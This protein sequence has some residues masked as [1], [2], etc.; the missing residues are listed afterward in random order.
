MD[1]MR[2]VVL[3]FGKLRVESELRLVTAA[4]LIVVSPPAAAQIGTQRVAAGL[5]A[6]TF[7]AAPPGDTERVFITELA[8]RILILNLLTDTLNATPFL[9]LGGSPDQGLQGL[10]FHPDYA[11]NGHFFVYNQTT[12]ESRVTRYTVST[13]PELADPSSAVTIFERDQP[14]IQHNGGWIGFGPDGYLYIP[15]GDGTGGH[16]PAGN[17]QTTL[18]SL[19]GSILRIDPD[20]DDFPAD[21]AKNYAIPPDNPF[22]GSVGD[23]EIWAFGLRNPFRCSFD[24]L[25]GDFYIADVG[26]ESYEEV[27]FQAAD[28]TGGENYGWRLREGF[29]ATPTGGVG[30]P[31]PGR[32]DPLYAYSHGFGNSEGFSVTGGYVYRGPSPTFYGKYFFGDY[33]SARIWSIEHDGAGGLTEFTDWTDA[34]TPPAGQ[35]TIDEIVGFGEDAVGNLY[36]VD[37]GGEVFRV[38]GDP[39]MAAVP[40]LGGRGGGVLSAG[41]LAIGTF[42]A[43]RRQR[44]PRRR[45]GPA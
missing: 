9:A 4:A 44:G 28:G 20:G 42:T 34:F 31:L 19:S 18:G 41:L 26:Q 29:D 43:R 23:D 2:R 36:I 10:A 35:G 15:L 7:L 16:D 30:G 1:L 6:P 21:P 40:A 33:V 12:T 11:V 14:M 39:P 17:A 38:F 32:T 27:N 45:G 37:L 24:R 8:G 13:D 22:V 5:S 3:S 25:T